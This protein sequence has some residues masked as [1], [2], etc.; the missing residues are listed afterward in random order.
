MS[1][2]PEILDA[3]VASGCTG[4]QIAAVVKASMSGR[5]SGA[6]RQAR[7][8]ARKASQSVTSDVTSV[9]VTE[10]LSPKEKSPTPPKEITPILNPPSPP[11]GGSSPTDFSKRGRR[12]PDDFMPDID[13]AISEGLS[14]EEARRQARSFCDYWASKPGK[15]GL[16]LDWQ[17]TWRVWFRR[18]IT[19]SPRSS[20][21]PKGPRNVGEAAFNDISERGL[22]DVSDQFRG[23][24]FG[25]DNQRD[26]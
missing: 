17:A 5:S 15:D 16:K 12:I 13:A 7:Y 2:T 20:S 4:E 22:D 25:S 11:K 3:M 8:R 26:H 23:Y 24:L 14:P 6:E 10:T 19:S 18:N 1:I 21:P 9:T